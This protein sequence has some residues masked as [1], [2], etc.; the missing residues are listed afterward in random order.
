MTKIPLDPPFQLPTPRSSVESRASD[1]N[2][3]PFNFTSP[4]KESESLIK[5]E[6]T[7]QTPRSRTTSLDIPAP[8]VGPSQPGT[9]DG[10][11]AVDNVIEFLQGQHKAI[12]QVCKA[13]S[14][15]FTK[16]EYSY[17][18]TGVPRHWNGGV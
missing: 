8:L 7:L 15:I 5:P 2:L 3:K 14:Y 17:A 1:V 13:L 6:H 18:G 9:H 10:K 16:P 12:I 4:A 11:G